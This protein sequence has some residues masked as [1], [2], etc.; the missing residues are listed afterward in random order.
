MSVGGRRRTTVRR[1]AA[2]SAVL[3]SPLSTGRGCTMR[4]SL[5]PDGDAS[6]A[7]GDGPARLRAD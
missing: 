5:G 2:F 1:S 7:H 3:A 6:T 4:R